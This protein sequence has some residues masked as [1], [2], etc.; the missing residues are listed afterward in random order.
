MEALNIQTDI[1]YDVFS[2]YAV[3]NS[4]RDRSCDCCITDIEIKALLSKPLRQL[5]KDDIYH[6]MTSAMTT[7]G[8]VNDYKH[9]LPRI[10]ELMANNHNVI[11]DFMI[12][13][14][15][16]H[17]HWLNWKGK[18]IL[19]IKSCFKVLLIDALDE[20][21]GSIYDYILLNLEYNDFNEVLEIVLNTN[22][23]RFLKSIIENILYTNSFLLDK[24]L[25]RLFS[26]KNILDKIENLFFKETDENEANRISIAYSILEKQN[27]NKNTKQAL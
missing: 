16:R 21:K 20:N 22:S 7:Y 11:I 27:E 6:F 12:F 5:N 10:L 15:L 23:K 1:L 4:L 8:D 13:E 25:N 3:E 2:S 18:E 26:N 24:R 9:F 17:S 19:A 14:K